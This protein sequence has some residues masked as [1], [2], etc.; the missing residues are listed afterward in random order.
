MRLIRIVISD[1]FT[2]DYDKGTGMYCV[3]VN[4]PD[5]TTD[6]WFDAYDDSVIDWNS[7]ASGAAAMMKYMHDYYKGA[8]PIWPSEME[9]ILEEFLRERCRGEMNDEQN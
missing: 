3:S 6:C 5:H 4:G 7:F 9:W 8:E 1:N 2:V